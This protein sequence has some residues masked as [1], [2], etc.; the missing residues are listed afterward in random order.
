MHDW[1]VQ[2]GLTWGNRNRDRLK[3][4]AHMQGLMGDLTWGFWN[5]QVSAMMQRFRSERG[6]RAWCSS[7]TSSWRTCCRT[8]SWATCPPRCGMST[9]GRTATREKTD[10][11]R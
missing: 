2:L 6:R 9:V 11:P 8:W 1:G 7:R 10:D 5:D 3:G 4:I